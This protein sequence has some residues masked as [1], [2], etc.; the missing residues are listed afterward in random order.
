FSGTPVTVPGTIEAE[1]FDN[2]GEGIAYHDATPGNAGGQYRTTD[3]DIEGTT[4]VNGGY[5]V[6]WIDVGEWLNYTVTATAA[7][8]YTLDARVASSGAGGTF[9]LE[10]N[11]VAVTGSLTIPNTGGWQNWTTVS[12]PIQFAAAGTQILR[13]VFDT[14]G[15][16]GIVGNVN[17]LRV[18]PP[19]SGS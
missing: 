14:A 19:T 17:Y 8:T 15:P 18:R 12:A 13:L 3:V 11:G 2:G 1:Q 5:D 10:S 4:D 9:H 7:G 16:G 6:G